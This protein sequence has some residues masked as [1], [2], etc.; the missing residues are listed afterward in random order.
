[1]IFVQH[2][3]HWG[4]NCAS[5]LPQVSTVADSRNSPDVYVPFTVPCRR[6]CMDAAMDAA[7]SS[8][9]ADWN[10]RAS[11][12]PWQRVKCTVNNLD[13]IQCLESPLTRVGEVLAEQLV[14]FHLETCFD[15]LHGLLSPDSDKARDLLI[16]ANPK[17]SN[18][19]PCFSVNWLLSCKL[20]QNL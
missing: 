20:L 11:T 2:V 13:R 9:D 10:S 3:P 6:C 19:V 12:L 17:P 15:Q 18:G 14:F 8:R 16:T 1:V 7:F 4:S 5:I